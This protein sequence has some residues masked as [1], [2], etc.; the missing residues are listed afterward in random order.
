MERGGHGSSLLT[1]R[2]CALQGSLL[3]YGSARKCPVLTAGMLLPVLHVDVHPTGG[4]IDVVCLPWCCCAVLRWRMVLW[5]CVVPT[6]RVVLPAYACLPTRVLYCRGIWCYEHV[7]I[8]LRAC[9][10]MLG[11]DA[12]CM[13]LPADAHGLVPCEA[14]L[15][16]QTARQGTCIRVSLYVFGYLHTRFPEHV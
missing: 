9:Y 14:L 15:C 12:A 16:V 8:C 7:R 6:E 10:T 1:L 11:T 4:F 3:S 13:V 2:L 5:R